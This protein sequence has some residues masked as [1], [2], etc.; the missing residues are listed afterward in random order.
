MP[1]WFARTAD[2]QYTRTLLFSSLFDLM[3][4]VV[5]GMYPSIG[6]A[7]QAE[8]ASIGVRVQAVYDK[9]KG[10]EVT[11]SAELVRDTAAA[12]APLIDELGG[13]RPPR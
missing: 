8:E 5:C 2:R 12:V 10:V 4:Q 11:T 9:L 13:T 1:A 7:Y 6:A 3:S